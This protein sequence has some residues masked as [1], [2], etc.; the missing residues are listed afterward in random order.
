MSGVIAETDSYLN[1]I[2]VQ[3]QPTVSNG[4]L[5]GSKA[6]LP[7]S[8]DNPGVAGDAAC[9]SGIPA[10]GI[11]GRAGASFVNAVGLE[12]RGAAS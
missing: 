11:V 4:K 12:C 5:A 1:R 6:L 3:C 7:A 9:P 10:H 8:S 2:T